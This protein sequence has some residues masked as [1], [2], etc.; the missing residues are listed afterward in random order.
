MCKC[1]MTMRLWVITTVVK[2]KGGSPGWGKLYD[3]ERCGSTSLSCCDIT[4]HCQ[5]SHFRVS[6]D[7]H[8]QLTWEAPIEWRG[9]GIFMD[10]ESKY[11]SC[12]WLEAPSLSY[13]ISDL[14]Y[15]WLCDFLHS[16]Q[17]TYGQGLVSLSWQRNIYDIISEELLC[18]ICLM[19]DASPALLLMQPWLLIESHS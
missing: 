14:I 3:S 2:F 11:P 6:L 17:K 1:W 13:I 9:I 18:I 7:I 12:L 5:F 4:H 19:Q 16:C 15:L 8:H 10:K